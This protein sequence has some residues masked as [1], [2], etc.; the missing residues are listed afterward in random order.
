MEEAGHFRSKHRPS[1]FTPKI[2]FSP[3]EDQ[4]LTDAVNSI[5]TGDW[6][7]VSR[8]V[9][10]RKPRQCRER[11]TNYL[12]PRLVDVPWTPEEDDLLKQKFAEIGTRWNQL[13]A[14][15]PSRS[16]NAVKNR[17]LR[18]HRTRPKRGR[19][20]G[21]PAQRPP[22]SADQSGGEDQQ[23]AQFNLLTAWDKINDENPFFHPGGWDFDA[24]G[25]PL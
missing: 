20:R 1:Y 23:D 12:D 16:T 2:K 21:T 8:L 13:A 4:L 14:V 19:P 9:A 7:A 6:H 22:D 11:W 18:L 17:C 15:F 3:E 5:G 24:N 10:S 25:F